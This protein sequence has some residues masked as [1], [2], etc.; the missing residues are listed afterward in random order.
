M[1]FVQEHS[2]QHVYL[3][4][5]TTQEQNAQSTNKEEIEGREVWDVAAHLWW[6]I[7]GNGLMILNGD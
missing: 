3:D 7:A 6:G 2:S 5:C 4:V 1:L